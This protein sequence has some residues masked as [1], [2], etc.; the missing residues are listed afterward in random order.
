MKIRLGFVSNSSASS[1]VVPV[2]SFNY[3]TKSTMRHITE[4]QEG[5]LRDHHFHESN[6]WDPIRGEYDLGLDSINDP[7]QLVIKRPVYKRPVYLRR[8]VPINQDYLVWFLIKNHIPF[9]CSY[10]GDD[11]ELFY[12][13]KSDYVAIGTNFGRICAT[14][15]AYNQS[16]GTISVIKHY[17]EKGGIEM[18]PISRWIGDPHYTMD[19]FL[20]YGGG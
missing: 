14:H 19:L 17:M 12:D 2:S 5:M 10:G 20:E 9:H 16:I 13:G 1:F 15:G 4:A 8:N 6:D 18:I 3:E 11:R 7:P